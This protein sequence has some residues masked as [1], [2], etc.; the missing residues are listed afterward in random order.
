MAPLNPAIPSAAVKVFEDKKAA[1]ISGA[2]MPFA[3][4]VDDNTGA[5]KVAAGSAM[6]DKDPAFN[7]V[8][9]YVQG[10]DGSVPK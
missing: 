2:L 3:G 7:S 6:T 9:W 4:P 5:V 10:V 8:N 1:L